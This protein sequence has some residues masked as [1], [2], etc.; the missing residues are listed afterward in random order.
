MVALRLRDRQESICAFELRCGGARRA[1]FSFELTPDG[2]C[3]KTRIEL[4]GSAP[5]VQVSNI[6]TRT[7]AHLL[8]EELA[9]HARDPVYLD[10]LAAAVR[11][12][13]SIEGRR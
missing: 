11:L 4:P 5:L 1:R 7:P 13:N 9:M 6:M 10:A 8:N 2:Q 12:T 3:A